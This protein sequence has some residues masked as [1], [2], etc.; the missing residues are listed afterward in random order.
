MAHVHSLTKL[1]VSAIAFAQHS[2]NRSSLVLGHPF[3]AAPSQYKPLY[4]LRA[5]ISW[6]HH[7]LGFPSSTVL[8]V[9]LPL[10]KSQPWAAVSS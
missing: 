8:A 1:V 2:Q 5:C 9:V 6:E 10:Q 3:D 4:C 7:T